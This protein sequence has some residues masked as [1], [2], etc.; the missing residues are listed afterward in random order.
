MR[1]GTIPDAVQQT[2]PLD[3]ADD[4]VNLFGEAPKKK[5]IHMLVKLTDAAKL[6]LPVVLAAPAT[7][8]LESCEDLLVFLESEMTRKGAVL[9]DPTNLTEDSLQFRLVGREKLL[10]K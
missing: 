2:I 5:T 9:A 4:I 10:E 3:P 1:D 7:V 6:T 8:H